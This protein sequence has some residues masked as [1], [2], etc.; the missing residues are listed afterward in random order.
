[1]CFVPPMAQASHLSTSLYEYLANNRGLES[2]TVDERRL[3]QA[4][5]PSTRSL[6]RQ[7]ELM[8]DADQ[9]LEVRMHTILRA[10]RSILLMTGI[11]ETT[12]AVG[13]AAEEVE[14]KQW[15]EDEE[16]KVKPWPEDAEV[17]VKPWP[18]VGEVE[19]KP[20]PAGMQVTQ[21]H[22]SELCRGSQPTM[23]PA[24]QQG[25]IAKTVD[26]DQGAFRGQPRPQVDLTLE[27]PASQHATAQ[28][29][30]VQRK[31]SLLPETVDGPLQKPRAQ[32]LLGGHQRHCRAAADE[33]AGGQCN[34][35]DGDRR[36]KVQGG[37]ELTSWRS[38]SSGAAGSSS[39]GAHHSRQDPCP[40]GRLRWHA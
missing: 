1:V 7:C 8:K 35:Q 15:P 31:Q 34:G 4:W 16:V 28:V 22:G 6:E 23:L 13:I 21:E 18:E 20:W 11:G 37:V 27:L 14:A 9:E 10:A 12:R 38:A 5:F 39:V 24:T 30:S 2:A 25:R 26:A 3:M 33:S 32:D 17:E 36:C 40:H 19:V 29:A